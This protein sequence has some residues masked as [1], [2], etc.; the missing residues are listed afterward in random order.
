MLQLKS[1]E[2]QGFKS[3]PD[4]TV[5]EFA[6]GITA[7]VGPNG[8]GKSNIADALRWVMGET[9]S[10]TL[11]GNK[12]EDVIFDGTKARKALG[13]AQVTMCFDNSGRELDIDFSEVSIARRY[14]RS[15]NSEY[16]INGAQVRLKDIQV[17]LRDT[18]LGKDGYSIIGQGAV[19]D[20]ISAKSSERRS[21]F[22]E[23]AGISG[24]KHR[25]DESARKLS[26]TNDNILRLN[27]ILT[28]ISA[29]LPILEKQS[30]KARKYIAYREEKKVLDIGIW[31][32]EDVRLTGENARLEGVI[33]TLNTD[34]SGCSMRM[35]YL[36]DV[37]EAAESRVTELTVEIESVRGDIKRT[38]DS[39]REHTGRI[40]VLDNDIAHAEAD[41]KR[42]SDESDA[43]VKYTEELNE[44]KNGVLLR[45]SENNE[46]LTS[47]DGDLFA[48]QNE[49]EAKS[50]EDTGFYKSMADLKNR[51]TEVASEKSEVAVKAAAL[52]QRKTDAQDRLISL[53]T[54]AEDAEERLNTLA[55]AR[56]G[57]E[58]EMSAV[59][60]RISENGN[61]VKGQSL[62]C[63]LHKNKLATLTENCS[64]LKF[65]LAKAENR[66]AMLRDMEQNHEG[67]TGSVHMVIKESA[68]G[69]LRG[70]VGTVSE[71]LTVPAEYA[72]AVEVA[73]GAAIQNIVTENEADAKNAIFFLKSR[74]GGRAT[75]LPLTS[76]KG[77]KLDVRGVDM[78][79]G[80]LGIAS[81]L[82]SFDE[83]YRDIAENL[84]GRTVIAETLDDASDIAK[85]YKFAFR[86]VT[87]D[88][89]IVNAGGSM[90]GGSA[91]KN[92]GVFSRR[93]ELESLKEKLGELREKYDLCSKELSA[94]EKESER[95]NTLL[96]GLQSESNDL[97]KQ[98]IEKQSSLSYNSE[99]TENIKRQISSIKEETAK[100]KA[101]LVSFDSENEKLELLNKG[102]VEKENGLNAELAAL[103]DAHAGL[104]AE[105]DA[106][107][108]R[109]ND[110]KLK[111]LEITNVGESLKNETLRIDEEIERYKSNS[112]NAAESIENL[113]ASIKGCED[114]KTE[115]A[116]AL[117]KASSATA[118]Y[119]ADITKK[120]EE[121]LRQEKKISDCRAEEKEIYAR[122]EDLVRELEKVTA[123]KNSAADKL[124][125]MQAKLWDEY[126]VTPTEA[127]DG[128]QPPEDIR[129]ATGRA[130]E[131]RGKLRALGEVNVSAIEEYVEIK[132]RHDTLSGQIKD[133]AEA[134]ESLEKLI[135][136]LEEDMRKIF[137]DKFKIISVEFEKVFK[138]MFNGG[139]AK[140]TLVNDDDVLE[141]GIEIYVAP[142]GKIIK[143][144]SSLSGGEQALT[145]ISLYFALM[146]INPSPFCLFDEIESAL[147]DVNV[148]RFAEYLYNLTPETQIIAI[149]H[150]RGTMEIADRLYG[151]TM[152]E[153]G[154]SKII[155]INVNEIEK[156][157]A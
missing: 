118:G 136:S 65:E 148:V 69:I 103:E 115:L 30:E 16:Y 126:E 71:I 151:V 57:M 64:S 138:Q 78:E 133:L 86:I 38:E 98:L 6:S 60:E 105:R 70:I 42:L 142:P 109:I 59:K 129:D 124:A 152:R 106:L 94:A 23:A 146:K 44:K 61:M 11:R 51:M 82:I 156:D 113:K 128:Y 58:E 43:A 7:I 39:V 29:R 79:P 73:L 63:E 15:G 102:L 85:R 145:A 88:G 117:E 121:R 127:R 99:Y 97:E 144:M 76:I 35:A 62:K 141:S 154:I 36:A 49:L 53:A 10:K 111:R 87:K 81:D 19:T 66:Y 24:F 150:R 90:T 8:S 40:M 123:A 4:K 134:K 68:R 67:F 112:L 147:D 55:V 48:V 101:E 33:D 140:L 116:L 25:R 89:Q 135:A 104:K 1:L 45:I 93:S 132:E 46:K 5:I 3:F 47:L 131:L 120:T 130:E 18:G 31:L 74:N 72:T 153:K 22:E 84:L 34:L 77:R 32:Y 75:F 28:E 13:F 91:A 95:L 119:D 26:M 56:K 17:L 110:F 14:Y 137:D 37:T 80:Y 100:N 9:S 83:R 157:M 12:M 114:E 50:S 149:T 27:D 21:V 41:I 108:T 155:T 107:V 92:A 125:S 122:K 143:N 20:I 52:A 96:S 139:E 2:L 54:E